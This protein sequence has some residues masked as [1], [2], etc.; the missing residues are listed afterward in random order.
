MPCHRGTSCLAFQLGV[1]ADLIATTCIAFL[2]VVLGHLLDDVSRLSGLFSFKASPQQHFQSQLCFAN[3]GVD[4]LWQRLNVRSHLLEF[5]ALNAIFRS[6]FAWKLLN[7]TQFIQNFN[8]L[9]LTQATFDS[10]FERLIKFSVVP[11]SNQ[12]GFW[13]SAK[14]F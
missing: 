11:E 1:L 13:F 9:V 2:L 5:Q 12:T 6:T 3:A 4:I 7:L 10:L 8:P 14:Q